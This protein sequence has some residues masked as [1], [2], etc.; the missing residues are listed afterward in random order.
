MLARNFLPFGKVIGPHKPG[1][2]HRHRILLPVGMQISSRGALRK[3]LGN[4]PVSESTARFQNTAICDW[5]PRYLK[6]DC[7]AENFE[8]FLHF[9]HTLGHFYTSVTLEY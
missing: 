6:I 1:V 3:N 9:S 5:N 8:F 4:G 7:M 2:T